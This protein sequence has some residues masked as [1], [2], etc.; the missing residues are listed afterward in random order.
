[1]ESRNGRVHLIS[2]EHEGG[3]KLV[4]IGGMA[5]LLRYSKH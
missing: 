3:K 4:S 1:V 5:T 2:A